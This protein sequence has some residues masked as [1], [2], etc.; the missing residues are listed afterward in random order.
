[1]SIDFG[2]L[3]LGCDAE[4]E[5]VI[6]NRGGDVLTLGDP[7]FSTATGD[8][9]VDL[10]GLSSTELDPGEAACI[11]LIYT[12]TD[13]TNDV[14]YLLLSSDDA[15]EPEVL[16]D[17]SG[18]GA[19]MS[20]NIDVFEA[21]GGTTFALTAAPV[22]GS[23]EVRVEGIDVSTWTHD[24]SANEV[25]FTAGQQPAAGETVEIEYVVSGC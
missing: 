8:F 23:I 4:Q 9:A 16:V 19:V 22:V 21:S 12:P 13:E 15:D 17:V 10:A 25:V 1:M 2:T 3:D 24:S 5:V 14:A 20:S 11:M 6:E 18:S 7:T